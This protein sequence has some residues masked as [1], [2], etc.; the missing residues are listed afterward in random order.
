MIRQTA[1]KQ[2]HS[3]DPIPAIPFQ[4]AIVMLDPTL[5]KKLFEFYPVLSKI[6][7][8]LLSQT[9]SKAQTVSLTSGTIVFEELQPCN[10]FPFILSGELRVFKQALNGRELSLYAVS[11]GDACVVSAG[12]LLGD[13]PYN[14]VGQVKE[15]VTLVMMPTEEFEKLL[16]IRSFREYIFS[17]FSKR[18]LELMQLVNEVAFEKLDRRLATFLLKKESPIR[19][20]HQELA[21]ELGTVREIIT[22]LLKNFADDRLIAIGREQISILDSSRL[23]Q[24]LENDFPSA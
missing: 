7:K 20:S 11:P 10:A 9:L 16:G 22:R 4:L 6:D 15:E 24:V 13:E 21:D 2:Y 23:K 8:D 1:G 14:A 12:C 17:L 5:Q 18:V 3:N 19:M